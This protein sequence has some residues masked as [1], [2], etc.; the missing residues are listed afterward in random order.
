MKYPSLKA[1]IEAC[2]VKTAA[3]CWEWQLHISGSGYG[4]MTLNGKPGVDVYRVAYEAY[5]GP[6]PA[7]LE[8]DHLCR[9]RKCCN[10][11]HLEPVTK[12]I[13]LLRGTNPAALNARKTMCPSGHPYDKKNTYLQRNGKRYCRACAAEWQRAHRTTGARA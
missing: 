8:V 4:R 1:R 6:I 10:P 11:D 9:N 7:G 5:R 13:N 12:R 2:T 3:G